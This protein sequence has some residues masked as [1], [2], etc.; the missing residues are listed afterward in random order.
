[1]ITKSAE[2]EA[3]AIDQVVELMRTHGAKT[4]AEMVRDGDIEEAP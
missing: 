1:M 4:Y 2:M 3:R